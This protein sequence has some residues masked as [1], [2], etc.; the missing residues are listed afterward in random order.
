MLLCWNAARCGAICMCEG[1]GE[2]AI[3]TAGG[4]VTSSYA[5]CRPGLRH[6]PGS[7]PA[8]QPAPPVP[9]ASWVVLGLSIPIACEGEELAD[10]VATAE[11]RSPSPRRCLVASGAARDG[12]WHHGEPRHLGRPAPPRPPPRA[13]L[14]HPPLRRGPS[15]QP[16]ATARTAPGRPC[17]RWLN[18]APRE[19]LG[20]LCA[21]SSRGGPDVRE[22][23]EDSEQGRSRNIASGCGWIPSW[24]SEGLF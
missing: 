6:L 5:A 12:P 7:Q 18:G 1:T 17:P 9:A 10:G 4:A 16:P 2:C 11:L 19:E 23:R 3:A 8:P 20:T 24:D 22:S 15:L 14:P 13:A 21:S